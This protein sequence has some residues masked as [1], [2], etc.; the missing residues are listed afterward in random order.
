ML[1]L[2]YSTN[3]QAESTHILIF[4]VS[5]LGN[6]TKATPVRLAGKSE[7]GACRHFPNGPRPHRALRGG[8]RDNPFHQ[9]LKVRTLESAVR[10]G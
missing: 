1:K 10:V 3:K 6:Q 8:H 4:H 5:I 7:L 9:L 2:Y